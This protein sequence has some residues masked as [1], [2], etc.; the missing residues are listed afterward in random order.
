[1]SQY[2]QKKKGWQCDLRPVFWKLAIRKSKVL[3]YSSMWTRTRSRSSERSVILYFN[4]SHLWVP[5]GSGTDSSRNVI[6]SMGFQIFN[7]VIYTFFF[8]IAGVVP[9]VTVCHGLE[10]ELAKVS[11]TFCY[12][13]S[14]QSSIPEVRPAV[15]TAEVLLITTP[16]TTARTWALQYLRPITVRVQ[17]CLST[18]R[19]TWRWTW[20]CIQGEY[21]CLHT[22]RC[23][24]VDEDNTGRPAILAFWCYEIDQPLAS[25][26]SVGTIKATPLRG[27]SSPCLAPPRNTTPS[28][29][30]RGWINHRLWLATT[31]IT[32]DYP[33]PN[34][35][36][37]S[38]VA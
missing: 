26:V 4:T 15:I 35:P 2:S 18:C 17:P 16:K 31:R 12:P 29:Y 1:M 6:L 22:W 19:W 28:R 14:T 10:T 20:T 32:L 33:R 8:F 24:H 23:V 37:A 11:P 34:T 13:L 21:E 30:R 5:A 25:G 27:V 9:E 7:D 36:C 3:E 38:G